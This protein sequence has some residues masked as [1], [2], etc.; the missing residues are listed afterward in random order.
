MTNLDSILLEVRTERKTISIDRDVEYSVWAGICPWCGSTILSRFRADRWSGTI[1]R[2]NDVPCSSLP[3]RCWQI[4]GTGS[5]FIASCWRSAEYFPFF[6]AG[7]FKSVIKI[8]VLILS[9]LSGRCRCNVSGCVDEVGGL[10]T[11]YLTSASSGLGSSIDKK[12]NPRFWSIGGKRGVVWSHREP[13][14]V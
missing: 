6:C 4:L 12:Q 11:L 8:L 7:T 3:S 13:W 14:K 1:C 5:H 2:R 10:G 9:W